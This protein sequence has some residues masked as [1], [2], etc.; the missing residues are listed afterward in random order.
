[1][2]IEVNKTQKSFAIMIILLHRVE[3]P[4]CKQNSWLRSYEVVDK[5]NPKVK[6]N[7]LSQDMP[8]LLS[9]YFAAATLTSAGKLSS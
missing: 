5:T 2:Q 7:K 4:K 3:A 9:F 8:Y 1:M 6:Y